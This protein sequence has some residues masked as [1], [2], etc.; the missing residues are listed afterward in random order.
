MLWSA[1]LAT[2]V[3][4]ACGST[5]QGPVSP[6]FDG[7]RCSNPGD[8]KNRSVAG[9]LRLRLTG[10]QATWPDSV[11][12]VPEPPPPPRVDD[13][14]ARVTFIGHA[15]VL[16]QVAGLNI[17]TDPVWSGRA[18][19]V[20]F[21]GPT[22]VQ[23]PGVSFDVLSRMDVVLISPN[24]CDHLDLPTLRRL[25]A[26]DRPRVV[27]PL[28][29]KALV[30]DGHMGRADAVKLMRDLRAQRATAHHLEAFHLGFEAYAAPRQ[31]LLAAVQSAQLPESRFVALLPGQALRLTGAGP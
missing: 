1:L 4:S 19:P 22:R 2:F 28:G 30:A 20:G 18:S 9:W 5:W 15:T 3:L 27:V 17:L 7:S 29:N 8:S 11:P 26:R 14:S 24:H 10:A 13:G 21:A 16:I 6:H 23:A 12:V 25:D 31:A